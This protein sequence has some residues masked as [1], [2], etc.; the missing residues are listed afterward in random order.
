MQAAEQRLAE[1][2]Y[3]VVAGPGGKPPGGLAGEALHAFRERYDGRRRFANF[4]G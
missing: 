4:T 2:G 1:H 3:T